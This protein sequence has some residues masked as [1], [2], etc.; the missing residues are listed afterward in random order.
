MYFVFLGIFLTTVAGL[1][2]LLNLHET[3][4]MNCVLQLFLHL[5]PILDYYFSDFHTQLVFFW[6]LIPI[7][8]MFHAKRDR[9]QFE[10]RLLLVLP[11]RH[12]SVHIR[13]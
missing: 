12:G 7:V 4:S 9:Q 6:L 3:D 1:K 13:R 10:A 8:G 11:P 5:P 2:G